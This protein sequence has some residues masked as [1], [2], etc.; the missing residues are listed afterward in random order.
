MDNLFYELPPAA[1]KALLEGPAIPPPP[2]IVPNFSHPPSHRE[3]GWVVAILC[4]SL[5]VLAVAVRMYAR[6]VCD[7]RVRIED[8]KIKLS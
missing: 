5:S 1:Q 6:I 2:G 4:L 7:K 3:I 8:C